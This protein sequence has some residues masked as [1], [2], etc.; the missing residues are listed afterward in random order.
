MENNF[1]DDAKE[2]NQDEFTKVDFKSGGQNLKMLFISFIKSPINT[3]K[4]VAKAKDNN[5]FNSSI[6][7]LL[8]WAVI[9]FI[10]SLF[11]YKYSGTYLILNI[12]RD[13]TIPILSVGFLALV[14]HFLNPNKDDKYSLT[15]AVTASILCK[16]P[17]ILS[18]FISLLNIITSKSYVITTPITYFC[19]CISI[20]FT[21]FA[22]KYLYKDSDD[23]KSFKSF[24]VVQAI[25]YVIYLFLSFLNVTLM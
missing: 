14:I 24:V 22:I 18:S 19:T 6:I 17:I 16:A 15:N 9:V 10:H 25:Y 4:N 2:N 21:F 7:I 23:S 12:I 13:I 11:S 1:K 5:I 3:F 20:I 8:I